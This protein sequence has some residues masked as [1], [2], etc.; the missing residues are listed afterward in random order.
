MSS[1]SYWWRCVLGQL[2]QVDVSTSVRS[3]EWTTICWNESKSWC[4]HPPQFCIYLMMMG[5]PAKLFPIGYMLFY[6]FL[7]MQIAK[8]GM[9]LKNSENLLCDGHKNFENRFK[10]SWDNWHQR[11]HLSFTGW[12]FTIP[13]GQKNNFGVVGGKFDVNYFS[14]F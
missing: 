6:Q 8:V 2:K 13:Q 14:Y 3:T 9:F 4:M 1:W 5:C 7:L 12:H 11:W 10:N